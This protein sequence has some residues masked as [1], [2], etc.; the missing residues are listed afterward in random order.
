[1]FDLDGWKHECGIVGIICRDKSHRIIDLLHRSLL[2][3]Q[4][5]GQ[6]AAGIALTDGEHVRKHKGWGTVGVALTDEILTGLASDYNQKPFSPVMG[7]GH[8]RYSTAGR[9]DLRNAQPHFIEP[10]SGRI[11]LV[12]N[13]DVAN[14]DEMHAFLTSQTPAVVLNT[15][16]DAEMI[17]K[18]I[19]FFRVTQQVSLVQAIKLMA[20]KV[21]G[22][23]SAILMTC[24]KMIAFRDSLGNRP[25]CW[26]RLG[27]TTIYASETCVLDCVNA[28]YQGEVE[29][30]QI[31]EHDLESGDT[32]TYNLPETNK[33]HCIFELIYFARPDSFV[34]GEEVGTFR[35]RL[36]KILAENCSD[37]EAQFVSPVPDSGIFAALGFSEQSSIPLDWAIIK[38]AHVA[39]TFIIPGQENRVR[40]VGLKFNPTHGV[41]GSR[42]EPRTKGIFVDDSIV[43]ATTTRELVRMLKR[44][45]QIVTG[46]LPEIH[47]RISSP[48]IRFSCHYGT[49]TPTSGELVANSHIRDGVVDV[50]SIARFV[51]SK[52]LTYLSVDDVRS[53]VKCPGDYCY[54]CF[55]GEYP[56]G[57]KDSREV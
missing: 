26:G 14:Y 17:L 33:A 55:N 8:V 31:I 30:G 22:T 6:E 2:S 51:G 11:V 52:T 49:N 56:I 36:G 27:N 13:G 54:A 7:V 57:T 10:Y 16:N 9:S 28:D 12:S 3:L 5:R 40:A 42:D 21:R 37:L 29:P 43:R 32:T 18:T 19:E 15:R 38:N 4:H 53:C 23:Y 20:E 39:R 1:M 44:I 50:P 35:R 25:F 34:F 46:Q 47:L 48:P 45:C 24:D 41:W